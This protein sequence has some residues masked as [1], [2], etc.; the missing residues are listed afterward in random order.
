MVTQSNYHNWDVPEVDGDEDKWGDYLRNTISDGAANNEFPRSLD[1][2]VIAKDTLANRPAAG[3]TGRWFLATDEM[4]LYYDDGSSWVTIIGQDMKNNPIEDVSLFTLRDG[5]AADPVLSFVNDVDT[6]AYRPGG[7]RFAIV[8][9]GTR[10]LEGDS[11]QNVVVP[12]GDVQDDSGNVIF[13]QSNTHVPSSIL[14]AS[15]LTVAGKS[16]S[17]GGS[18]AIDHA[19]LSTV[20]SDQHHSQVHGNTDH[21]TVMVEDATTT[22]NA[23][24]E[25][26]KNGTDGTGVINF[27]T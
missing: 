22:G 16:V 3:T 14:Q 19:D 26:Q 18:T 10:A 7:G 2:E 24:Y 6:G 1:N 21:S 9:N 25:I 17:L 11:N 8:T 5:T 12:N 23:P 4:V 27:K 13:D 15:S 20:T